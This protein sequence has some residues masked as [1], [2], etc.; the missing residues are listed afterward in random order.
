M[1]SEQFVLLRIV[2]VGLGKRDAVLRV[3]GQAHADSNRP[4][5]ACRPAPYSPGGS[6]LM[7][8]STPLVGIAGNDVGADLLLEHAEV[9]AVVQHAGLHAVPL[10]A[11]DAV[12]LAA[13]VI[14]HARGRHQIAFVGGVDE[15]LAR[16][17]SCR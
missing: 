11:V 3:I 9:M 12:R 10:L 1:R 7:R 2:A 17:K 4:A 13:D 8:G 14:I 16:G 5:R 6:V 15:H